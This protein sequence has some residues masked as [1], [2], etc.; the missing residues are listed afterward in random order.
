MCI[1]YL[2]ITTSDQPDAPLDCNDENNPLF[3]SCLDDFLQGCYQP[4]QSGSCSGTDDGSVNWSDG[5]KIVRSGT[6]AGLYGP[7]DDE[8]CIAVALSAAGAELSK[9]DQKLSYAA[10]G[11]Q[12]TVQCPD[13]KKLHASGAQL[14]SFNLCHGV[15][16]PN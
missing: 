1:S 3:G 8:P 15:N 11:D 4:D 5:S 14:H 12:V 7:G 6:T 9:G 10:A 13:G 2:Y 16:C